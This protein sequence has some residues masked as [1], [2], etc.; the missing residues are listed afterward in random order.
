MNRLTRV[1]IFDFE[2]C[3]KKSLSENKGWCSQLHYWVFA[4][5]HLSYLQ[6]INIKNVTSQHSAFIPVQSITS[7]FRSLMINES[8][9]EQKN[10]TE[11]I[12]REP[13]VVS[14]ETKIYAKILIWVIRSDYS[15][16]PPALMQFVSYS[17]VMPS[18]GK[19]HNNELC[20]V[21]CFF[22]PLLQ[23]WKWPDRNVV[24]SQ[25]AALPQYHL[26]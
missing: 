24:S 25:P 8:S 14:G 12:R 19:E 5:T 6:T 26:S 3:S 2:V 16:R 7:R 10:N 1:K 9:D 22:L 11:N 20:S 13:T 15:P 21:V 23:Y 17:K 4:S 18:S